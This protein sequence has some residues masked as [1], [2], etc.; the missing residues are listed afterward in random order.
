[1]FPFRTVL[2]RLPVDQNSL[3][4]PIDFISIS[5]VGAAGIEPATF[6]V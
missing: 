1:M 5:V 6:P 2:K 4:N 3:L